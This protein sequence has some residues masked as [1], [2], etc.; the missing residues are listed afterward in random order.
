MSSVKHDMIEVSYEELK[1]YGKTMKQGIIMFTEHTALLYYPD[2]PSIRYRIVQSDEYFEKADFDFLG[3]GFQVIGRGP[4]A[5]KSN[6]QLFIDDIM[7]NKWK[8]MVFLLIYV[9]LVNPYVIALDTISSLNEVMIG[10]VGVYIGM[11]FVF[12]GFFYSDKERTMDV[13][14]KGIGYKE[15]IIDKYVIGLSII[16]LALFSISFLICNLDLDKLPED[17]VQKPMMQIIQ[18]NNIVFWSAFLLTLIAIGILII[19][20]DTLIN[21]YLKDFRNKYFIDAFE[22]HIRENK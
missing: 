3:T 2:N 8:L 11:L 9:L 10:V 21:Y 7:G 20:F 14:K 16:S 17:I 19:E 5:V 18:N 13:Y 12:I 4:D 6:F 22:E 15:Y 1:E